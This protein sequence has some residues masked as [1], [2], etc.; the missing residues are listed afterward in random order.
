MAPRNSSSL[1]QGCAAL[2]L[3]VAAVA[4]WFALQ[5]FAPR[6]LG[7]LAALLDELGGTA[8]RAMASGLVALVAGT[9]ALVVPR[10]D[11]RCLRL[12]F[13]MSHGLAIAIGCAA[14]GVGGI[15]WL[16]LRGGF[17]GRYTTMPVRDAASSPAAARIVNATV[18]VLAPDAE[19]D[20]KNLGLGTGAVVA[21][22]PSRAWI[23][24]CGHVAM[25]YGATA[26]GRGARDAP[27]VWV[28]LSDG[29]EG[30]A[31]V[32]WVAPPPLDVALVELP[33]ARPPEPVVIASDTAEIQ[34][35]AR[36]AFVPNPYRAGWKVVQGAV[37]GRETHR[38]PTGTYDLLL[39]DLPV[40][41]GD[42]G[43]GLFDA[44]GR[45]V[46]LNAWTRR[47]GD[48]VAQGIS[49]P[50][51]TLRAVV[52]AIHH[53]RLDELGD[54]PPARGASPLGIEPDRHRSDRRIAAPDG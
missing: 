36:V 6:P 9:A 26:A 3:G 38:A 44:R 32:R 30:K 49:L 47:R 25:P 1:F 39:T 14:L 46:G 16:W 37:V 11:P 31:T 33:I 20:A 2:T 13:V 41:F 17:V 40:T 35:H 28:Q 15:H 19:G 29:R 4:G 48:G 50:L 34:A 12:A 7:P 54:E 10:R 23:V 18:V 27:P 45:L 5:L 51:E 42:S 52:D 8:R 43:S 22:E 21:A 24:T 53:G